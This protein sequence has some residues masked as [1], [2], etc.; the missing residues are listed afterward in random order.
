MLFHFLAQ[1]YMH[2]R[3]KMYTSRVTPRTWLGCK[4]CD[5]SWSR[6]D[7]QDFADKIWS[8]KSVKNKQIKPEGKEKRL[9][10]GYY[11]RPTHYDKNRFLK[12]VS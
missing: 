2:I 12:Q 4:Y 1:K 5:V 9:T 8:L 3:G 11:S 10:V 6:D 7:L